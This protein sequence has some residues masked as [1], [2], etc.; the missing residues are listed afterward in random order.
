MINFKS[1]EEIDAFNKT[2]ILGRDVIDADSPAYH[3]DACGT[4]FGKA[5][6]HAQ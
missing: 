5:S 4:D 1:Q 6:D 2:G 3:C